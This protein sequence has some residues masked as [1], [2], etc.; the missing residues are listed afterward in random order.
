MGE[1]YTSR[2]RSSLT[3]IIRLYKN[4]HVKTKLFI[5]AFM[6]LYLVRL[7]LLYGRQKM[8]ES[9]IFLKILWYVDMG[10]DY[11][12]QNRSEFDCYNPHLYSYSRFHTFMLTSTKAFMW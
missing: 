10:E 7:K 1:N 4:I 6:H 3:G 2:S 11:S 5:Q 9:N 12:N 8:G